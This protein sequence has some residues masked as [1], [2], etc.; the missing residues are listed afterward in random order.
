MP[1]YKYKAINKEAK[2]S[3]GVME[4]K[5]D[6]DLRHK[7]LVAGMILLKYQA[8]DSESQ[9]AEYRIKTLELAEICFQ[10]NSMV[11]SGIT[12]AR[13]LGIMKSREKKVKLKAI[14]ANM[15]TDLVQGKLL[16]ESMRNRPGA[17]PE[18]L[19][20]MINSG[21]TSGKL[22][23]VL[24]KMATH[25]EKEHKINSKIKGAMAY[26]IVLFVMT[27][28]VVLVIFTVILP[29]FFLLFEGMDLPLITRIMISISEVLQIRWYLV[30]LAFASMALLVKILLNVKK[31]RLAVDKAKIHMKIIGPLLQTIYTSRFARTLSS[32]YTSGIPIL[33]SLEVSASTIN[34]KYIEGQFTDVS[35]KVSKGETL[36]NSVESVNGFDI[37]LSTSIMIGEESGRLT[38]MLESIAD[39]FEHESERATERLVRVIEPIMIVFMA[40]IVGTIMI[41]V[42]LPIYSLYQNIG[43]R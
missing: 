41:S 17:F 39:S 37:K 33:K 21:E 6:R 31:I 32:L 20:N 7:A 28:V 5:D 27:I 3:R 1:T 36:A 25:Y 43:A 13:A 34:N 19:I 26:P 9:S 42:M 18:M 23:E 10:L 38:D 22:A 2:T 30:I 29:R 11:S 15:E 40:V 4:A 12:V 8:I 35:K 14:Y 24:K 16:S